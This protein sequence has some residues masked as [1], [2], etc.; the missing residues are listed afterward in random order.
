MTVP[1]DHAAAPRLHLR[2]ACAADM[3]AVAA[4]YAHHVLTGLAS[5]EEVPP[6]ADEMEARRAAVLAAGLPYLVAAIDGE[7][8]GYAYATAYRPRPAYRFTLEDSVYVAPGRGGQGIGSGLLGGLIARCEAGPWRQMIAVIGNSGNAGSIALHRRHGF[9]EAGL[10]R[11]VGFKFGRWVDSVLMQRPLGAGA[12][13]LP[14]R[15]PRT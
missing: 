7:V 12:A 4:I 14:E 8:V 15:Q 5:F 10:L 3:A 13:N 2:D 11:D 1:A 6:A 9:T